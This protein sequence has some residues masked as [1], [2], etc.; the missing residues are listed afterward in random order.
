MI[1]SVVR[2]DPSLS[3]ME[4]GLLLSEVSVLLTFSETGAIEEMIIKLTTGP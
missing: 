3:V 4:L 1:S 2:G